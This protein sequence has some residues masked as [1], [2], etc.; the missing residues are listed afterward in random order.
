MFFF[1]SEAIKIAVRFSKFQCLYV[2]LLLWDNSK[3]GLLLLKNFKV[4]INFYW[5]NP[6]KSIFWLFT[7]IRKMSKRI[8]ASSSK[9]VKFLIKKLLCTHIAIATSFLPSATC[10]HLKTCKLFIFSLPQWIKLIMCQLLH[11]FVCKFYLQ[12]LLWFF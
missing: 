8:P 10:C 2:M 1:T 12:C 9:G 4:E 5:S 7:Y 6:D 3:H 11:L